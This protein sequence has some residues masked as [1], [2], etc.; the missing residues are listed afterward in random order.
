MDHRS[1]PQAKNANNRK[2][3]ALY[4][5]HRDRKAE[6]AAAATTT[7]TGTT[8]SASSKGDSAA[9]E[10]AGEGPLIQRDRI[11]LR[12][13]RI[14]TG[15]SVRC[16]RSL[17]VSAAKE[18]ET[19]ADG[20]WNEEEVDYDCRLLACTRCGATQET[21][22]MQL[23][24]RVGFRA[25]HCKRCGRQERVH[26]NRCSCD[27]VWHQCPTHRVDP[28]FHKSRN[29]VGRENVGEEEEA[30]KKQGC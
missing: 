27:A 6:A 17:K 3:E 12:I 22:E 24:V 11:L 2:A 23:K 25:I 4:E 28:P 16:K 13:A 5:E 14:A 9:E 8:N 1:Y 18:G 30:G 21:K 29:A 10:A 19:D 7:A 15:A 26:R 20:K